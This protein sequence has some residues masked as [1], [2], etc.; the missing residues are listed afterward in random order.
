MGTPSDILTLLP[1]KYPFLL[2]DR[3]VNIGD[4]FIETIKNVTFNEQ[5][6]VGHFPGNPIMPGVLIIEGMAQSGG[7]LMMYKMKDEKKGDFYL[8]SIEKARFRV[9]VVPGDQLLFK[10]EVIRLLKRIVKLSGKA[11][12]R[13]RLVAESIFTSALVEK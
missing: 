9:P 13:D 6:F 12:V 7:L 8:A 5:F 1:H 3:I 4:D 10:V 2:V 11:Y